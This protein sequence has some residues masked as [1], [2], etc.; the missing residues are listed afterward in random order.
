MAYFRGQLLL[1][2]IF[3]V[4]VGLVMWGLGL[5][6]ALI[7]GIIS[8]VMDLVPTVGALVAGGL[9]VIMALIQGSEH[10]GVNNFVFAAIV[11]G[12]Y[13]GL[14]Q[15]ES[16]V[17]QPRIMGRSVELPGLVIIVGVTVGATVAG[18][19]GAYLAVPVMATARLVF[20]YLYRKLTEE[21]RGARVTAAGAAVT[22]VPLAPH[23]GPEKEEKAEPASGQAAPE[24]PDSPPSGEGRPGG[25]ARS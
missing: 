19:L 18:V 24:D 21:Q 1:V 7:V 5:P 13:L 14:Q 9:A 8:A 12:S 6:S 25:Q 2:T 11:L 3:G 17:L 20:L 4:M 15:V 23:G 22:A 10:I 16:S